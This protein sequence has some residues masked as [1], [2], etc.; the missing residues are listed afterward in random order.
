MSTAVIPEP[1][2]QLQRQLDQFRA[3]N[4]GE[5]AAGFGGE[6]PSNWP[7]NTVCIRA[8][9][10]RLDYAGLKNGWMEFPIADEKDESRHSSS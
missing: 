5:E 10:L 3:P 9:P 4:H 2:A 1:I 8:H 6:P 7:G